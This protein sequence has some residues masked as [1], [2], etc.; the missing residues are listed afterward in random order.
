[1]ATRKKIAFIPSAETL[2]ADK[3]FHRL[4]KDKVLENSVKVQEEQKKVFVK[5]VSGESSPD[6]LAELKSKYPLVE[7]FIFRKLKR[8]LWLKTSFNK[9]K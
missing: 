9:T 5:Y 1:M 3:K 4:R 2:A 7:T 8:S 6:R